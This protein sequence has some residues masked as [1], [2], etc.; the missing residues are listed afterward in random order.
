VQPYGVALKPVLLVL[1]VLVLTV[2]VLIA[3]LPH[4]RPTRPPPALG[5]MRALIAILVLGGV[6]SILQHAWFHTPFL[7]NRTASWMLPVLLLVAAIEFEMGQSSGARFLRA[8]SAT[9][10]WIVAAACAL[11]ASLCANTRF[12]ILQYHDADT[13]EM[14]GDLSALRRS[15]AG[16]GQAL[17]LRSSWELTPAIEYYR[18][19]RPLKWLGPVTDVAGPS[20]A[21]F[22]SPKDLGSRGALVVWKRYPAT[23]NTLLLAPGHFPWREAAPPQIGSPIR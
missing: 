10:V 2:G 18:V 4:R 20:D 8:T 21:A 9:G 5:L 11:H 23:G 6:G 15:G 7:I 16:T 13:K 12:A 22:V 1:V 14:L 3:V 19:T 17:S